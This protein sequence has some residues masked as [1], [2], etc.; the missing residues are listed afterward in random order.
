MT[1]VFLQP[2]GHSLLELDLHEP[3]ALRPHLPEPPRKC[4]VSFCFRRKHD[5]GQDD[6]FEPISLEQ[7]VGVFA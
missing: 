2:L 4:E 5:G 6:S 7:A 1:G 3:E